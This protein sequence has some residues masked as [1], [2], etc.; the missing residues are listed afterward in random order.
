MW[1]PDLGPKIA[2]AVLALAGGWASEERGG[3]GQTTEVELLFEPLLCD[4][5]CPHFEGP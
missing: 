2:A 5:K 4:D 3:C 1:S